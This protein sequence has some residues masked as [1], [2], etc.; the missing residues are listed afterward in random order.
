MRDYPN[1]LVAFQPDLPV[2]LGFET[3]PH[4]I[5]VLP[6]FKA[7]KEAL[8]SLESIVGRHLPITAELGQTAMFGPREDILVRLV[9]SDDLVKL[10]QR[11]I[12][13]RR[14]VLGFANSRF[15]GDDFRPHITLSGTDDPPPGV[16]KIEQLSLVKLVGPGKNKRI[17]KIIG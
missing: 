1:E 13:Q 8:A 11:L 3:W 6:W 10:H 5:T 2:G 14:G 4:H 17:T 16:F 15:T 9:E 7:N 12:K